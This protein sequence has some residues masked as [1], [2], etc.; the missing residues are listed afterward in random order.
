MALWPFSHEYFMSPVALMPAI[1]R[2]YWLPGF[3]AHNLRALAFELAV[4]TPLAI[5]VWWGRGY[6]R[7]R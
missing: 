7:R 6:L 3:W 1:S 5:A 2:R 4:L